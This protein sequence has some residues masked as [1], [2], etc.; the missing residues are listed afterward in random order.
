MGVTCK[1]FVLAFSFMLPLFQNGRSRQT[2]TIDPTLEIHLAEEKPGKGLSKSYSKQFKRGLYLHKTAIVTSLDIVEIRVQKYAVP[3]FLLQSMKE[4]GIKPDQ[5]PDDRYEIK[6]RLTKAA[7]AKMATATENHI[8]K[9]VAITV[10][11]KVIHAAIVN[12]RLE[13]EVIIVKGNLGFRK[14]EAQRI[15]NELNRK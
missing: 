3:E 2:A 5:D 7:A 8:G 11:G 13:E 10:N 12:Q 4:A 15:G 14:E 6:L 1:V 9:P